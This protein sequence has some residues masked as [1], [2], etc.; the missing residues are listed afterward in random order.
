MSFCQRAQR[1]PWLPPPLSFVGW[2]RK[3]PMRRSVS[4]TL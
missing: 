3:W 1:F 2:L 4:A